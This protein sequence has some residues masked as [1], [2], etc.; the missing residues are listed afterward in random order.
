[1][2]TMP[3]P[4][5]LPVFTCALEGAHLVEASAGT[6]KTWNLCA[7]YLRLLLERGLTVEQ[8]LVVTFTKA[9]TSELRD[10]IRARLVEARDHLAGLPPSSAADPFIPALLAA[11]RGHSGLDDKLLER[12][13]ELALQGFDQAAISTIHGFCQRALAESVFTAQESADF[14]VTWDGELDVREVAADFWRTHVAAPGTDPALVAHLLQHRDSPERWAR[15]LAR[16]LARPTARLLWPVAPQGDPGTG[17]ALPGTLEA[18]H[19]QAQACWKQE[20]AAIVELL[21][22]SRPPL[23]T[24]HYR[25]DALTRAALEWD[26]LLV[27]N[28]PTQALHWQPDRAVLM[29][30]ARLTQ[31]VGKRGP[32]P[33][34]PFFA[35]AQALLEAHTGLGQAMDARR[36][37][38]LAQLLEH[39]PAAVHAERR[40]RRVM[41]FDDML[42]RLHARL[43]DAATR[44]ALV[45]ALRT[46]YPAALIDEFQDTDPLQLGIF[47]ALYAGTG[48]SVFYVGDPK[49]AIYGFRNA[50]LHTY[51]QARSRV[52]GVYTLSANQRSVP[53]LVEG[54]NALFGANPRAFLLDGLSF[55]PAQPGQRTRAPLVDPEGPGCAW[56]IRLLPG[57]GA[58]AELLPKPE[59]Q[60]LALSAC[61]REIVRLLQPGGSGPGAGPVRLG[62]RALRA[63]DIAVL[64]RTRREGSLVKRALDACG[65]GSVESRLE[66]IYSSPDAQELARVLQAVAEPTRE[67]T[68]RTAWATTLVGLEAAQVERLGGDEHALARWIER[69]AAWRHTWLHR[70]VGVMLRQWMAE[71]G[72]AARLLVR[73]DGE[74]RLTNL[75]HLVETLQA[76]S[77]EHP[78]PAALLRWFETQRQEG[79]AHDELQLRLESDA[80]L[81]QIQTIH[82]AKGLEYP[83]VICPFLWNGSTAEPPDDLGCRSYHDDQGQAVLD[84]RE[85]DEPVKARIKQEQAAE[86]LRLLYV[87]LTRAINRCVV[88]AGCYNTVA[89]QKLSARQSVRS[90]LNWLVAGAG[91]APDTWFDSDPAPEALEAAWEALGARHPQAIAVSRVAAAPA[92]RLRPATGQAQA[93]RAREAPARLPRGM[94]LASYSQIV[95]RAAADAPGTDHDERARSRP[96]PL[97]G[98]VREPDDIL[99]FPASAEAG[100]CIHTVFESVDFGDPRGWDAA[101]AR[102]L[103]RFAHIAP[104]SGEGTTPDTRDTRDTPTPPTPPAPLAPMLRRML[105]DVLH[106][107]LPVGTARPL[108]LAEVPA[109]QRLPELAFHFP[110]AG[111]PVAALAELLAAYGYTELGSLSAGTLGRYLTGAIDLVFAHDGRYFIADW[112][113][114]LLGHS[115]ADYGTEPVSQEMAAERY[116]L[117]YL[118]YMVA[119]HRHLRR[120]LP[121][122]VPATHLGG[123]LYLFVRGVRPQ[124]ADAQGRPSGLHFDR[125]AP[126]LVEALSAL[127]DGRP[128]TQEA[129]A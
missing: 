103:A 12:R 5:A 122:Y 30:S 115:T 42:Q 102:A 70:G 56:D 84:M 48:Q 118:L 46:R 106:T 53:S 55:H 61:V 91:R 13:L 88:V 71:E 39:G 43:T 96:G 54:V 77:H 8:I 40:R 21:K 78:S 24:S 45:Q 63:G 1:M 66:S 95:K 129:T 127:L 28:A 31:A 90:L 19:A 26:E 58:G 22:A 29:T 64:V 83:V 38:L 104:R 32:A 18:L 116:R 59:A 37:A 49:Q 60:E 76:A 128:A 69:L 11:L 119:L 33:A 114:N 110:T 44:A 99:G 81:V 23:H 113:S 123:A 94:R 98:S 20:R 62:E 87:A 35:I 4:L 14:E 121:G 97:P 3:A 17:A 6:G 80:N 27:R 2:T 111:I 79:P 108:R 92:V 7:L 74:R 34:H 47:E 50:D 57:P 89:G 82:G 125:P 112:K 51:L 126:E 75:L 101:I 72:V 93:P 25:D 67:Q 73:S 41:T 109:R 117:Q 105:Q 120:C 9:A 124:W 65:V 52:Q 36:T 100:Q 68:L 16:R 85:A 10:R 15:L 107:E 86:R